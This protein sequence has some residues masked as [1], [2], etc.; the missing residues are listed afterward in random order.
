MRLTLARSE[1][2]NVGPE[3]SAAILGLKRLIELGKIELDENV[4]VLNT[5]AGYRYA[6]QDDRP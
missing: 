1:G 5:G 6:A 2:L 4:V 3:T